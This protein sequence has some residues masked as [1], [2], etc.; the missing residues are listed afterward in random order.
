MRKDYYMANKRVLVVGSAEQ[1]G[2][3]VSSAIRQ[4][5]KM[6]VWEKYQCYWL[7]T[8]IQAGKL[9]KLR[10]ALTAYLK[11][12]FIIWR[13]D[14]VHFHTVPNVSMKIQLPV[15]LLALL[16]RKKIILHLHVG[17]QLE[18]DK[19]LRYRLFRWC[20]RKSDVIV[21]LAKSI[22]KSLRKMYLGISTPSVV[23]YNS[24]E[25]VCSIPYKEHDKTI[26][27]A[28]LFSS[29]KAAGLLIDAFAILHKKYP[30]WRLQLLGNGPEEQLYRNKISEYGLSNFVDLPGYLVGN[31][32][33]SYFKKA[34]IY[35][36]CSYLEGLPMV[37]IE[38]WSYGVPVVSTPVGG[39][40][41]VLREGENSLT[42]GFGDI[43]GLVKKLDL[44]MGNDNLREKMS[45]FSKDF[46]TNLFSSGVI[47]TQLENLYSFF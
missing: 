35:A 11:A 33:I 39:L 7:G 36:M 31:E 26:L 34:G 37:V 29:N 13:Y 16:G 6:P 42:F 20:M 18:R 45:D 9:T 47:N 12:L 15:F 40:P 21:L 8:Q 43:N 4:I 27:F 38:A 2:G 23:I 17:N 22:E 28:G 32:K 30:D 46:V 3:G 14:I 10:Y 44:L 5:K 19:E 41:D 25:D 1:S 24:C